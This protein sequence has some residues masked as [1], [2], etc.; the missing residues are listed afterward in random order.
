MRPPISK[1]MTMA[2][3]KTEVQIVD[4]I[5]INKIYLVRK[6]KVMID[7][8]LAELYGVE[9]KRLKEA[10]R[11]NAS[12]FPKDFMFAMNASEFR[13]WRSQFVVRLEATES[14]ML[15]K[16]WWYGPP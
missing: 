15:L 4:E 9:T 10:I 7:R 8:D 16:R 11:R 6:Q 5:I 2:K 3:K 12:R 14:C 13:N 1:S